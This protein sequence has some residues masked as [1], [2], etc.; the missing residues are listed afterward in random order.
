MRRIA[1]AS[2]QTFV[3]VKHVEDVLKMSARPLEDVFSVKSF[4]L[5]R[6]LQDVFMTCLQDLYLPRVL[7]KETDRESM[8]SRFKRM[9]TENTSIS[10]NMSNPGYPR[11]R[12]VCNISFTSYSPIHVMETRPIQQ[13]L[14]QI[15]VYVFTHLF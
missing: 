2:W 10:E 11:Y 4:C 1:A 13:S 3:L 6:Y 14:D 15:D 9:E 8:N 7:N 12:L 5:P